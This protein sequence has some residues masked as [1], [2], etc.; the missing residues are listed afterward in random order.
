MRV[1]RDDTHDLAMP[2]QYRSERRAAFD[3]SVTR[4]AAH[5]R[6]KRRMMQRDNGWF[7]RCRAEL[8]V[9]PGES[10]ATK[11]ALDPALEHG[12]AANYT[13]VMV[14]YYVV[15]EGSVTVSYTHLTLPTILLV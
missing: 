5:P 6:P 12:I 9:N 3:E 8:I 4:R 7:V 14:F 1:T 2:T 13:D 11:T 10:F 15:Q